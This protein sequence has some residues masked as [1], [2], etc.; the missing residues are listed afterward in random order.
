MKSKVII[1][2]VKKS[3]KTGT[4]QLTLEQIT[5]DPNNTVGFFL[6]GHK[7]IQN[8][9][10][11]RVSWQSV[12]QKVMDQYKFAKDQVLDEVIGKDCNIQIDETTIRRSWTNADNSSGIQQAKINP[13]SQEVLK[14]NGNPIYRN[15]KLVF[16]LAKDTLLKHDMVLVEIENK[17]LEAAGDQTSDLGG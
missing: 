14:H 11:K 1:T 17:V 2:E 10:R 3:D 8:P 4:Y 12:S 13:V 6:E 7:G 9:D 5:K 16:G 15:S